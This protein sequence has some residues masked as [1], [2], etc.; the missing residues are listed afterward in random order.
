MAIEAARSHGFRVD[1][2][3][4]ARQLKATLAVIAPH[5]E[6][7]LQSVPTVPETTIVSTY[8]LLGMAAENQP[9]NDLTDAM[10]HELAA[11]QRLDGR[12]HSG[13]SRPPLD[14]GDL[15]ATAL[16]VRALQLYPIRGRES[17]LAGRIARARAW[18][19]AA[20]AYTTQEKAMRVFGL[21]WSKAP[22]RDARSAG[23]SLLSEQRPDGGWGQLT[24]LVSDAYATGQALVALHES[25]TLRVSDP[26][27]RRGV[28]YLLG[29]Q[30]SDGSWHVK[31]RAMG[32]QP[33]FESGYPHGHD[34]WISAAGSAWATMALALTGQPPRKPVRISGEPASRAQ[35]HA[36]SSD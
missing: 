24:T 19:L 13:G 15:T 20:K 21:A 28:E 14:Q 9:A 1:Q 8:T 17:E 30:R 25:G 2:A 12:W 18:M 33:Y 22:A 5:R 23:E 35:R 27:Y 31:S 10:V 4:A 26:A 3:A 16:S 6:T 7:L 29:T 36:G 34:Q 11:R 32:F